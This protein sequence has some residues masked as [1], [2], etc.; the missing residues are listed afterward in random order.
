MKTTINA[1]KDENLVIFSTNQNIDDHE[2]TVNSGRI[3]RI[4]NELAIKYKKVIGRF[5]GN[6][7]TSFLIKE[8]DFN[9]IKSIVFDTFNQNSVLLIEPTKKAYIAYFLYNNGS[10]ERKGYFKPSKYANDYTI[11]N[12]LKYSITSKP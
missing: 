4:M 9:L 1:F 6:D 3:M 8:S 2:N 11:I 5:N 12:N 7:E 10:I